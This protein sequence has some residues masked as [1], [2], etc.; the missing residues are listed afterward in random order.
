MTEKDTAA[1][2]GAFLRDSL[3][4]VSA[5]EVDVPAARL[6]KVH[7]PLAGE[8]P[9][10]LVDVTAHRTARA[11][12]LITDE[13]LWIIADGRRVALSEILAP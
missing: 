11:G 4:G 2:L 6:G 8:S 10:A 7:L 12:F 3:L 1:W 9:V 13:A 5:I